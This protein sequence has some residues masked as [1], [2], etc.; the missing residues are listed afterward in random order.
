MMLPQSCH[1]D[2]LHAVMHAMSRAPSLRL[3]GHRRLTARLSGWPSV[4]PLPPGPP[5]PQR[6]RRD[7][8]SELAAWELDCHALLTGALQ[9]S[10]YLWFSVSD[11]RVPVLTPLSGT[12]RAR[13]R[14]PQV[15]SGHG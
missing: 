2:T 12:Q 5:G 13:Q 14:S 8:A 6:L 15:G 1:S 3:M 11:R 9:V 10:R 7:G 4:R